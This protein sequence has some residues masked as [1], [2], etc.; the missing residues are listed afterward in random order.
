[1]IFKP[2]LSLLSGSGPARITLRER[3][4]QREFLALLNFCHLERQNGETCFQ[5]FP[6]LNAG[7][8]APC[9]PLPSL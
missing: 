6:R 1:M 3:E 5:N 4:V 7:A 8:E 9:Y 2:S